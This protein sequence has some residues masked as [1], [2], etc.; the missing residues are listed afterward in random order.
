MT[1]PA[2]L[3]LFLAAP[4]PETH[5]RWVGQRVEELEQRW[6]EARWIPAANQHITLKFLGSTL[7][8]RLSDVVSLCEQVA[9]RHAAAPVALTELGVFP[10][11]RRARVLWIGI[12]DPRA[13]LSSLA[14]ALDR[15]L[16][17]VGFAPEDKAYSPHLTVARF[18]KPIAV[19]ELPLLPQS[20]PPFRLESFDLWRSHLSPRGARYEALVSFRLTSCG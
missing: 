3:R 12:D 1:P 10:S 18:K 4:V 5:L 2:S 16:A 15:D 11:R 20:P 13:L 19:Q 17:E 14:G 8:D 9:A 7:E 6:P